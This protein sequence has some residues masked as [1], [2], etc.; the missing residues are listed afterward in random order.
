MRHCL[1]TREMLKC[2]KA[3]A[4]P[5]LAC[6]VPWLACAGSDFHINPSEFEELFLATK[7]RAHVLSSHIFC[8]NKPTM[9][10]GHK[11]FLPSE[12]CGGWKGSRRHSAGKPGSELRILPNAYSV[13]SAPHLGSPWAPLHP[14]AQGGETLPPHTKTLAQDV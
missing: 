4:V 2:I 7:Q 13:A 14:T 9:G 1:C 5:W 8:S 11:T 12:Q 6:A 10:R 3:C